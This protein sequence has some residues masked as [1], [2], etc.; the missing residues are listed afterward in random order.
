ME[1]LRI[2]ARGP[3]RIAQESSLHVGGFAIIKADTF[4]LDHHFLV[5]NHL[6]L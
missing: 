4:D 2:W 3:V 6:Q 1:V 5:I